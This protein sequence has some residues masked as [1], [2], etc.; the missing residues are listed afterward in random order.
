MKKAFAVAL[1]IGLAAG[2]AAWADEYTKAAATEYQKVPLIDKMCLE[3]VKSDPDKHTTKCLAM[4]AS[5]GYGVLL[6]DG[7]YLKF[8]KAGDEKAIAALKAT[9]KKDHIRVSVKGERDGDT[10]K[11]E[12]LQIEK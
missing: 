3:K 7:T 9:D 4:C 12:N 6:E 1:L 5:S 8:D 2:Q 10:F 11:V